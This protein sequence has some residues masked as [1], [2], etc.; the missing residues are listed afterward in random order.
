M[1]QIC[2][3]LVLLVQASKRE[4]PFVM[5]FPRRRDEITLDAFYPST[6]PDIISSKLHAYQGLLTRTA[7]H[8]CNWE[9]AES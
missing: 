3:T 7:M 5:A 8:A 4:S 2:I 9:I 6:H 1:T